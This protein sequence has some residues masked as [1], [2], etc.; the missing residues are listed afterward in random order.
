[1]RNI[2]YSK[3][4][5]VT[6]ISNAKVACTTIKNSMLDGVEKDIHKIARETFSSPVDI[7]SSFFCLTRNPYSRALSCY[8]DKIGSN[9]TSVD[10]V[11][12]PFSKK[13][14]FD[15]EAIPTFLE[16]LNALA[17]DDS[18][19]LMDIHYR[20]QVYN[21]HYYDITPDFIGRLENMD[22]VS[23]YLE[24][25][26]ISFIT[27]QPNFT[28]SQ[29][30]YKQA[31]SK[32]E[33]LLINQIYKKDFEAFGYEM[34]LYS[35]H[36]PESITQDKYISESYEVYFRTS[37][38]GLTAEE[39][40]KIATLFESDGDIKNALKYMKVARKMRP[41]GNFII[42]KVAQYE[43][44]LSEESK[45]NFKSERNN[46]DEKYKTFR[47]SNKLFKLSISILKN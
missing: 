29:G 24:K 36:V 8:K 21:L 27:K 40:K 39:L 9:R 11:W 7:G 26:G 28:N 3:K 1:M 19:E 35:S 41:N 42:S 45:F 15:I 32:E 4:H 38:L 23:Q 47:V 31:I 20:P 30:K 25:N 18:P 43:Q 6:F 14:G 12:V 37:N 13:Y 33:E 34:A 5:N 44:M 2:L 10:G 46:P 22:E 17:L 16:F